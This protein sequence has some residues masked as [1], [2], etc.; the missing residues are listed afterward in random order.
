MDGDQKQKNNQVGAMGVS[1]SYLVRPEGALQGDQQGVHGTDYA[2]DPLLE[3]RP[4]TCLHGVVDDEGRGPQV[5]WADPLNP[6]LAP[7]PRTNAR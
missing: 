1:V 6:G 2:P 3:A 5:L 4:L 7:S